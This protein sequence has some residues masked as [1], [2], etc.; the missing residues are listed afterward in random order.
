MGKKPPPP[1]DESPEDKLRT[2]QARQ[3]AEEHAKEL[4]EVIERLRKQVNKRQGHI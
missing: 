1:P 2:E 3:A 4:R